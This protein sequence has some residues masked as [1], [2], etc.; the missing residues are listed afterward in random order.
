MNIS[1]N[2]ERNFMKTLIVTLATAALLAR[3][4]PRATAGDCEWAT[5]GKI[6]TGVVAGAAIAS[7][8]QP[9]PAYTYQTPTWYAPPPPVYVQPAPVVV[10]A[11]PV[12]VRPAPVIVFA[13]ARPVVSFSVGYG[14]EY[15]HHP[16]HRI[17]R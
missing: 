2:N 14:G 7:A 5:A 11:S 8:F 17:Y 15:H 13:P 3:G 6:L 9:A 16:H 10:Y 1:R 12:C 4:T